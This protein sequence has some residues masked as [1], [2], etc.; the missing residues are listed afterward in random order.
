[1]RL[2]SH[3][4]VQRFEIRLDRDPDLVVELLMANTGRAPRGPLASLRAPATPLV[5]TVGG[6]EITVWCLRPAREPGR[7]V[8]TASIV[9][10]GSGSIVKGFLQ[11]S[12]WPLLV[13]AAICL[14]AAY[15]SVIAGAVFLL[16]AGA[17]WGTSYSSGRRRLTATVQSILLA[18]DYRGPSTLTGFK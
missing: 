16:A 3:L 5:G 14:Y 4:S 13:A 11:V 18:N 1:M 7:P 9:P 2:K 10:S 12:V 8:L 6:R 15:L 17:I